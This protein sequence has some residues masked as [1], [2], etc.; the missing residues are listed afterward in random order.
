MCE[1]LE[2]KIGQT[3]VEGFAHPNKMM[4]TREKSRLGDHPQRVPCYYASSSKQRFGLR[5]CI[6]TNIA[7]SSNVNACLSNKH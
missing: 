6:T 1:R 4:L 7:H 3:L 5:Q 2:N